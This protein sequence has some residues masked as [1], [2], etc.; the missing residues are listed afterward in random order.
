MEEPLDA[1]DVM[2]SIGGAFG[3]RAFNGA[4]TLATNTTD[5]VVS[6]DVCNN[7]DD[8]FTDVT[9]IT[10]QTNSYT[11]DT[12]LA[13]DMMYYWKVVATDDDGGQSSRLYSLT[14]SENSVPTAITL[15]PAVDEVTVLPQPCWTES[16]DADLNDAV[17][18][19]F[20]MD[21]VEALIEVATG[22]F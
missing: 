1:D 19:R 16:N 21:Q 9:A 8:L 2:T 11:P 4:N 13:E 12:D 20:I 3:H 10:V 22:S 7:T 15:T 18:I 5:E 17:V 14:N 6:Y